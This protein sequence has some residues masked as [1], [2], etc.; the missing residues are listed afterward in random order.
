MYDKNLTT[1]LMVFI[2]LAVLAAGGS[3]NGRTVDSG[4]ISLGSNPSPPAIFVSTVSKI[5]VFF[6]NCR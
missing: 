2:Y 5:S 4:S 1:N 3:S 6:M